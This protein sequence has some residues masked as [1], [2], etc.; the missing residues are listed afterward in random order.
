MQRKLTQPV[1]RFAFAMAMPLAASWAMA[2]EFSYDAESPSAAALDDEATN[3]TTD[4]TASSEMSDEPGALPKPRKNRR[5]RRSAP[6]AT[7][8]SPIAVTRKSR[9]TASKPKSSASAIPAPR[10][11]SSATSPRTKTAITSTTASTRTSTK[12]VA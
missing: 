7:R 4:D 6:M 11:R 12:R 8:I 10:S 5:L 2:Q 1:L 9:R 3:E